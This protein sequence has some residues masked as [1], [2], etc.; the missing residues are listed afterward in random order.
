M[1][2]YLL[3]TNHA[4]AVFK[5]QLDLAAHPK[6]QKDDQF[7]ISL[8][9]IGELWFM[10]YNSSRIDQNTARLTQVLSDFSFWPFDEK[11]AIEFGRMAAETRRA[12]RGLAGIDCQIAAIARSNQ[13]TLL[14]DDKDFG[15]L[16][17]VKLENWLR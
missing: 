5:K 9:S 13:L 1:T 12:G 15:L 4:S 6:R 10:V 2:R 11:A 14:T 16:R 3:D 7:G 8:P 17:G